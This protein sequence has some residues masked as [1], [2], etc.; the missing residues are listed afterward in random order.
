AIKQEIDSR[1]KEKIQETHNPHLPNN[2]DE[3]LGDLLN[4]LQTGRQGKAVNKLKVVEGRSK[5]IEV[6]EHGISGN[7][8]KPLNEDD[9]AKH[10]GY[11]PKPK[12]QQP[13][14]EQRR[15]VDPNQYFSNEEREKKLFSQFSNQNQGLSE[16]LK[17]MYNGNMINEYNTG[18]H[19]PQKQPMMPQ[20]G[21][22]PQLLQEQ[23][24]HQV[25]GFMNEHFAKLAEEALRNTIIEMYSQE[26]VKK[27][28]DDIM[29]EDRV[30]R[31]VIETIRDLQN[32]KKNSQNQK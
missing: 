5:N 7:K 8:N 4:S 18:M 13:V 12:Q 19:Q 21:V 22:N 9:L 20:G 10:V 31:I 28:M 1:K 23:I 14:N 17:N 29:P 11:A 16:Q 3:F 32:R 26:R 27:V 25:M 15:Q 30:R 6:N 2:R 24:Q